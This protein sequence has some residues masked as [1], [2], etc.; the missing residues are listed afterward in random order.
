MMDGLGPPPNMSAAA[1]PLD[2][3][4]ISKVTSIPSASVVNSNSSNLTQGSIN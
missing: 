4:N 3:E 1:L 2:N